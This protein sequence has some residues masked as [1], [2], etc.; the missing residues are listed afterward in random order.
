M[1][2]SSVVVGLGAGAALAMCLLA[3]GGGPSGFGELV[4]LSAAK[5]G[6][7]NILTV[8]AAKAFI[9]STKP[10]IIDVKDSS[11]TDAIKN[12]K[13]ISIPLSNLVFM[14]DPVRQL[15]QFS[16]AGAHVARTDF[17]HH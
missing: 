5:V 7:H 3:P 4:E 17:T 10:V 2:L 1:D 15:L 13:T 9:A 14:A 16:P 12:P 8:D 6:A 11:D